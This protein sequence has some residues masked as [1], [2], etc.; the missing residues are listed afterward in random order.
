MALIVHYY[1]FTGRGYLI[2]IKSSRGHFTVYWEYKQSVSK[3]GGMVDELKPIDKSWLVDRVRFGERYLRD[4]I[5]KISG[6]NSFA[7]R[8]NPKRRE[9]ANE[10]KTEENHSPYDDL[11]IPEEKPHSLDESI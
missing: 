7:P 4:C 10:A 11:E 2:F 3:G 8:L 9:T 5:D 1:R 6:R